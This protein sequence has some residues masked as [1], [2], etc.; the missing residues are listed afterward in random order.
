MN[1]YKSEINKNASICH[2]CFSKAR[3]ER[4]QTEDFL[5][6]NFNRAWSAELFKGYVLYLIELGIGV[7]TI[8]KHS[9]KALKVFQKEEIEL[10]RPNNFSELWLVSTLGKIK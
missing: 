9:S 5:K 2:L 10:I 8:R 7:E 6:E 3:V 4:F 1:M